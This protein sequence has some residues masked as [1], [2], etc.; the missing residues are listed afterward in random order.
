[1]HRYRRIYGWGIVLTGLM[2]AMAGARA[3]G[4]AVGG[5]LGTLGP[6]IEA[7]VLLSDRLNFRAAGNYLPLHYQTTQNEIDYD[8][9]LTLATARALFDVHPFKNHFRFTGG[10][11]YNRNE[12]EMDATPAEPKVVGDTIYF[13]EQIGTIN[14][15]VTF[16]SLAPYLGI[17]YGDA[18]EGTRKLGFIFD[19]GLMFQGSPKVSLGASGALAEDAGFQDDLAAEEEEIQ[20]DADAF[21]VYPVLA[22]GI[23]YQF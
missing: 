2:G 11:T 16:R 10:L 1:M 13:P 6:G 23:S 12:L 15:R 5:T 7:T 19:L 4:L 22:F 8:A 20:S 9:D 21:T 17:G 3:D 14:G 18:V